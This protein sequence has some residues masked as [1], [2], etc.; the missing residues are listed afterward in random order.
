MVCFLQLQIHA[1]CQIDVLNWQFSVESVVDDLFAEQ[2]GQNYETH[3]VEVKSV[4]A[5]LGKE[6]QKLINVLV[7]VELV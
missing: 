3:L 5:E 1:V 7:I 2:F 6:P 4:L